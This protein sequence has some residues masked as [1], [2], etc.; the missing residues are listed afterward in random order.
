MFGCFFFSFF[1]RNV[2]SLTFRLGLSVGKVGS[3]SFTKDRCLE[4]V[5]GEEGMSLACLAQG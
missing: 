1:V 2:V 5:S 3:S 4:E